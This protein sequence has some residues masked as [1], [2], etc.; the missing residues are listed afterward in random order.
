MSELFAVIIPTYNRPI[1]LPIAINS[2]IAQR[3]DGWKLYVVGD[4]C[5]ED[6]SDL[7]S[8][9]VRR[10]PKKIYW[11]NLPRHHGDLRKGGKEAPGWKARSV[12]YMRSSEPWIVYLDDDDR[13]RANHLSVHKSLLSSNYDITFTKSLFRLGRN[14]RNYRITGPPPLHEGAVCTP[15]IC[16][17]KDIAEK[18]LDPSLKVLWR[19]GDNPNDW[20]L[21]KRMLSAGARYRFSN[22]ITSDVYHRYSQEDIAKEPRTPVPET[23]R[24]G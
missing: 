23:L 6:I 11:E 16:H 7:M 3:Y 13:Y 10:H 20:I 22:E 18:I 21:V 14:P 5:S 15:G 2:V 4:R 9:Y 1:S 8:D 24:W 12:A 17:S 19:P